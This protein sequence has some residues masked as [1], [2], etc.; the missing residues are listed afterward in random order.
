[1]K[2]YLFALIINFSMA[3]NAQENEYIKA[4]YLEEGTKAPN[5]HYIGEAYLKGLLSKNDTLDYNIVKATFKANATLDWHY[6]H[7][8]QTIIIVVEG[9]AIINNVEKPPYL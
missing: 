7:T 9:K 1:M 5:T 6:H 3:L 4:S 2:K 8:S